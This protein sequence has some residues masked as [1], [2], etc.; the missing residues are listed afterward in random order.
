MIFSAVVH[1]LRI[2]VLCG[3]VAA[4]AEPGE[5]TGI[6]EC[7]CEGA[8]GLVEEANVSRWGLGC[9][10]VVI[11]YECYVI[12]WAYGPVGVWRNGAVYRGMEAFKIRGGV[13]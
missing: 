4:R 1:D 3:V 6:V 9:A 11:V 13:R 2:S 8:V 12:G 10:I 5:E 7:C